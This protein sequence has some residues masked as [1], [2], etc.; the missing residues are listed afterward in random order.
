MKNNIKTCCFIGHRDINESDCL[1]HNLTKIIEALI[2]NE[3][4][5]TFLLEAEVILTIYVMMLFRN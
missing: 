4:V 2:N 5:E 3:N 1:K